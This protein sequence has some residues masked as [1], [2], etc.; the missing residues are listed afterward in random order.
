MP[1]P[2]QPAQCGRTYEHLPH[3]TERGRCYGLDGSEVMRGETCT[4]PACDRDHPAEARALL[5]QAGS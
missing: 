4:S 5:P 1:R 3:D 2:P